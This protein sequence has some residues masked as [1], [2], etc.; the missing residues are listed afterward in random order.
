ME[1]ATFSEVVGLQIPNP[2]N[3][4]WFFYGKTVPA[5]L[6]KPSY[7][8]MM[9]YKSDK[10]DKLYEAGLKATTQEEAFKHF[11][12]AENIVM[13][14]APIMV[15]W[16]DEGY[17]LMQAFVKN[18]PNNAMQYRD[19]TNVYFEYPKKADM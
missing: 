10:F 9:R 2:E 16:Y 5:S 15:L 12:E 19:F 18:F 11:L 17:R 3:F 13:Q 8:N 6:E 7:P 4:L 1:K 14:D